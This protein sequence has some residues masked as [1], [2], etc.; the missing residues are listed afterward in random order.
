MS[1]RS[2][3]A[4]ARRYSDRLEEFTP[5]FVNLLEQVYLS[6]LEENGAAKIEYVK[7]VVDGESI[8]NSIWDRLPSASKHKNQK[9]PV[10]RLN[11][12]YKLIEQYGDRPLKRSH[13]QKR[14]EG[15]NQESAQARGAVPG[16]GR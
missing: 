11:R 3:G 9:T 8:T 14:N 7:E 2:L 6:K 10:C 15:A 16:N 5:L 13:E 1:R 12:S 4:N